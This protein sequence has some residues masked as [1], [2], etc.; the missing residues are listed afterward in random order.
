[1]VIDFDFRAS[2]TAV[3]LLADGS[4]RRFTRTVSGSSSEHRIN[5]EV[6]KKVSLQSLSGRV[7]ILQF[8]N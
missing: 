1:M 7:Y 6:R 8:A 4:E 3:F 5:H 2:V